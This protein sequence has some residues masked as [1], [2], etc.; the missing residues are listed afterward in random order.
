[1]IR[2]CVFVVAVV[3]LWLFAAQPAWRG[4][5]GAS[6]QLAQRR[7]LISGAQTIPQQTGRLKQE[8][9]NL[10][11]VA[12]SLTIYTDDPVPAM[13]EAI[14]GAARDSG[15]RVTNF[16]RTPPKDL[17]QLT[18]WTLNIGFDAPFPTAARFL[19]ELEDPVRKLTIEK[20]EMNAVRGGG[21]RVMASVTIS[22][23]TMRSLRPPPSAAGAGK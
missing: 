18:R 3:G 19:Y 22:A 12:D 5:Q 17:T 7:L 6:E 13:I 11:A 9:A 10:K 2:G 14:A 1:M 21:D 23:Y 16:V 4:L 15:V 8:I 20:V